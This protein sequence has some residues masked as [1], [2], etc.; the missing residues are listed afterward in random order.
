VASANGAGPPSAV[1]LNKEA[2]R[3][4]LRSLFD[5]RFHHFITT[6]VVPVLYVLVMIVIAGTYLMGAVV[7]LSVSPGLGFLWLILFGPIWALFSLIVF[8]VMLEIAIVFFRIRE[9]TDGIRG[10]VQRHA[11]TPPLVAAQA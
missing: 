5:Y 11:E 1:P 2:A 4:F 9:D 6:K 10:T 7:G 8:R 3:G